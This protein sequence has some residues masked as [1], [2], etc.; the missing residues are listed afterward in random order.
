MQ[1]GIAFFALAGLPLILLALCGVRYKVESL[2]R[3]YWLYMVLSFFVDMG[4]VTKKLLF[5]GCQHVPTALEEQGHAFACGL[6]RDFDYTLVVL[7]TGIQLYMIFIVWSHCEDLGEGGVGPEL[8]DLV[9]T[10]GPKKGQDFSTSYGA[11]AYGSGDANV[12]DLTYGDMEAM[13]QT[14]AVGSRSSTT[15]GV[16]GSIYDEAFSSGL[17]GSRPIFYKSQFHEVQYPPPKTK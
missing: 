6:T 17:G 1:V 4:V 14:H 10:A 15:F 2:V 13:M 9:G 12:Q 3:L 5:S 7:L 16:F 8:G 11:S